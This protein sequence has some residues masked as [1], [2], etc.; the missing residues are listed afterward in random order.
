M[1]L[2]IE[3][4]QTDFL[5]LGTGVAGLR[6]VAA[7]GEAGSE[8]VLVAT[9]GKISDSNTEHAQGGVAVVL[10]DEDTVS[11]HYEDTL[12]AGAGLCNAGAVRVLTEEGPRYIEELI[13][14]GA[15]FDKK[16]GT[17]HFSREGAHSARRVLHAGG[18]STGREVM[19]ILK[20]RAEGCQNVQVL[21][22][23]FALDLLVEDGACTGAEL[24]TAEGKRLV[25]EA[26]ATLLA[27]GG[28]GRVFLETT[29]PPVA[30]G[31]GPA[32]AYRAEAALMDLE[33][34][35]FHPTVLYQTG[36]PRFLLTEAL[37]GEGGRLMNVRGEPFMKKYHDLGDLAPRDVV[38]RSILLEANLTHH[39]CV[40]LDM[41]HLGAA[42]VKKRFPN[43]YETCLSCS[44]DITKARAPVLPAAHYF[45]GGVWTD[46][47]GRTTVENLYAAGE[48]ASTGV[49]GANRLASNSLL[50][51]LV[52][53]ARVAQ[54]MREDSPRLKRAS[55]AL[56][57]FKE[58]Y[59]QPEVKRDILTLSWE[60]IGI[61]RSQRT[62]QSAV[63]HME[64]VLPTLEGRF[65]E[66]WAG[67]VQNI[68]LDVLL[69]ARCALAR[70]ESRGA[71]SREDFPE[72]LPA[73]EHR[74][75]FVSREGLWHGDADAARKP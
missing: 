16:G 32:I 14:W 69:M 42:F 67:E 31:D 55:G 10:S 66:Q 57:E 68:A 24:L 40:Y 21:D 27:T 33:F 52:Y 3:R 1:S 22:N 23:T 50:E 13:A 53:G 8:K 4:I 15:A 74:H 46:L 25:V 62:L 9:K 65:A 56:P 59:I 28:A 39:P 5:V 47:W 63:E 72:T 44:V 37:R 34:F 17:L 2:P 45:M 26:R 58:H 41:T 29:N 61:S 11:L 73:W 6:A 12:G 64:R 54:A 75:S 49:H 36:A 35:Q 60:K 30:T 70:E 20:R 7:L 38:S 71:H 19:R 48:A 18:D 43:V 51:G